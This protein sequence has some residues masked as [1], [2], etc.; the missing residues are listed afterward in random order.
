MHLIVMQSKGRG[1]KK[2]APGAAA[3]RLLQWDWPSQAERLL[4][5]AACMADLDLRGL[6]RPQE[7]DD[8]LLQLWMQTV[9]MIP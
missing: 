5:G 6:F 9:C 7:P 2:A 4:K 1:R 3:E 8:R